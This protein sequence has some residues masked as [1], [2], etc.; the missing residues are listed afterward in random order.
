M[1]QAYLDNMPALAPTAK[2]A[3]IVREPPSPDPPAAAEPPSSSEPT[4]KFSLAAFPGVLWADSWGWAFGSVRTI[5]V[6]AWIVFLLMP[7]IFF[8]TV[9]AHAHIHGA[10]SQR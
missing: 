7:F 1:A 9:R 5:C 3:T 6:C 4:S 8:T 2:T 10:L